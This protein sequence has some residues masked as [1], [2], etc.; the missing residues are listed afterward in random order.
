MLKYYHEDK[1]G[2]MLTNRPNLVN[3]TTE[4]HSQQ[5]SNKIV[6]DK[7]TFYTEVKMDNISYSINKGNGLTKCYIRNN[8]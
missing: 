4:L 6:E 3:L 2:Y 8:P 7:G 5:K 1:S